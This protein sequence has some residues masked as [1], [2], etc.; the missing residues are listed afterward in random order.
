VDRERLFKNLTDEIAKQE[1]DRR[2]CPRILAV[3]HEE[4]VQTIHDDT[5]RRNAGEDY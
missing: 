1:P 4:H 3:N 5:S 2:D